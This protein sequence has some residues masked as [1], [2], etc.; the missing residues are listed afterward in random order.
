MFIVISTLGTVWIYFFIPETK[1]IPLEE[2]GTIFGDDVAVYAED[3]HVDHRTHELIVDEHDS[4]A[5]KGLTKVATET[6]IEKRSSPGVSK[7]DAN[8]PSVQHVNV[9]H[10]VVG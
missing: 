8:N 10:A 1:N 5:E 7:L 4:S 6:D 3:L 9:V 2:M